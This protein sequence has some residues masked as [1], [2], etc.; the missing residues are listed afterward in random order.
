MSECFNHHL[1]FHNLFYINTF[2]NNIIYK[3]SVMI[4]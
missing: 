4:Q 3:V 1:C 2:I